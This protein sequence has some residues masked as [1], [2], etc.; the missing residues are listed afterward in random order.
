MSRRPTLRPMLYPARLALALTLTLVAPLALQAQSPQERGPVLRAAAA[1]AAMARVIVRFK[2]DGLRKSALATGSRGELRNAAALSQ[3]AGITLADGPSVDARTQVVKAVGVS[4]ETLA[5][6]L[7]ALE[8]V[9]EVHVDR[10]RTALAAPNDPYYAGGTGSPVPAG[11]W[12]LRPPTATFVSAVNA[13]AAWDITTGSPN[14]IVAVLDTGTRLDHPDLSGK[15]VAGYDFIAADSP[16]VFTTANDGDGRDADPSDPGD[17]DASFDSSWH[18]TQTAG[19]IGATTNNGVGIAGAGRNVRVQPVRVLG[20]GGGYDSDIQAGMLW[21]A[22]ITVPGVPANSTPAKVINMSLGGSSNSCANGYPTIISQVLA[23]G[24]VIVAS[25]GNDGL[26]INEP[27]NCA[28]VIG[29]AGIRHTGTKV[30]YSSLGPEAAIAAPAG[31]CVNPTGSGPCLYPLMTTSNSGLQG[32]GANIYTGTGGNASIGTSFSAPLVSATAALMFSANR[33]L[34]PAQVTSLLKSSARAFPSSGAGATVAACQ[35]PSSTAQDECYC[36]TSTCGAGML[37]AQA[38]VDAAA[39]LVQLTADFTTTA[40]PV[41]VGNSAVLDAA[42]SQ[43]PRGLRITQYQWSITS[44]STAATFAGGAT[45]ATGASATLS[46]T[47]A[48]T[49]T[50]SLTITDSSNASSTAERSITVAAAGGG[51]GGGSSGGGSSGGGGGALGLGWLL[52]LA[53]GVAALRRRRS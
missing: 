17:W 42:D 8:D 24:V 21:A 47:A 14:V 23:K 20:S 12:Y 34:T 27:A 7:A 11:Q 51:S 13:E 38:A 50:V 44:G 49:V 5:K 46:A 9:E 18:G 35:A 30:G 16:G 52:A 40:N 33:Q 32:P 36:T 53:G 31:N 15:L 41:T 6:Q 39:A 37:N 1:D 29:V 43:V 45:T 3:R 4:S 10:K 22:G 19:L 2:A 48:G 28:G 26:A 25:A